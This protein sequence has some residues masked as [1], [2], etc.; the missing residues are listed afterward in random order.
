MKKMRIRKELQRREK[1]F[2]EE[3]QRRIGMLKFINRKVNESKNSQDTGIEV[4][5]EP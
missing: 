4:K 2:W 3:T 1:K 5:E